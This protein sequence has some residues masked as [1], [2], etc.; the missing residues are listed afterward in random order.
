MDIMNV[1]NADL[2]RQ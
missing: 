2:N 1:A